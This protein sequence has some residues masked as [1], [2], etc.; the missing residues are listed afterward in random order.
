M[1]GRR[2]MID[3]FMTALGKTD[4]SLI[5]RNMTV[6][7]TI[8]H[9]EIG[10]RTIARNM[11]VRVVTDRKTTVLSMIVRVEIALRMI[12]RS[13]TAHDLIR[14]GMIVRDLKSRNLTN[15]IQAEQSSIKWM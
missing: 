1:I 9:V 2:I 8:V 15:Q 13:M 12:G 7:S 14:I 11:I 10:L 4:R 6:L 5:V 3:R